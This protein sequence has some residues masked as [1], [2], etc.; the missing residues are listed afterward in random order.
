MKKKLSFILSL[1]VLSSLFCLLS[2]CASKKD[3]IP[4]DE[5]VISDPYQEFGEASL[6]FYENGVKRWWLDADFMSRPLVDTGSITVIPVRISMYDTL[7]KLVTRI[8]ADSGMSDSKMESF[9]LWGGVHIKNDQ[10][11]MTVI[12]EQLKWFKNTQKITSDTFVEVRTSKGDI[13]RGKGLDAVDNFSRFT[14]LS[15]VRGRFPDFRR[16]MEEQDEDFLR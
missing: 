4:V 5:R 15:E 9:N 7:G 2:G 16:R 8:R 14:F 13:L 10:N 11:G 6:Y 12:S 3:T 1:I